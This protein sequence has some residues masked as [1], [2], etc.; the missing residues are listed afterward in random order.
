MVFIG[1]RL[2]LS[3]RVSIRNDVQK[4]NLMNQTA[5]KLFFSAQKAKELF[6]AIDFMYICAKLA[7]NGEVAVDI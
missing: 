7:L 6:K 2:L 5:Q 3:T 1:K 4:T